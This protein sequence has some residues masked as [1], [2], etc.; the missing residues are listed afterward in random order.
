MSKGASPRHKKNEATP[1]AAAS[2]GA[3]TGKVM[4]AVIAAA[5]AHVAAAAARIAAKS[6]F[7]PGSAAVRKKVLLLPHAAFVAG[8]EAA[9]P[10]VYGGVSKPQP[11]QA[12]AA[13]ASI[14]E[15]FLLEQTE[16]AVMEKSAILT[17][18]FTT[19]RA[20]S[21]HDL[22]ARREVA[23]TRF[24][25]SVLHHSAMGIS[26][27]RA[28]ATSMDISDDIAREA[29]RK[30]YTVL[31]TL[32]ALIVDEADIDRV[33]LEASGMCTVL[34]NVAVPLASPLDITPVA[35]SSA[36][37]F[38][39]LQSVK[40]AAARAKGLDG[41]GV[42]VGVL[43]TGIDPTHPE[44]AGKTIHYCEFDGNGA[45]VNSTAHDAGQ[46][47]TH[48]CG[49]IA[50]KN[51]GIAPQASL[52]VAGVLNATPDGKFSGQ[53]V[54]IAAGMHWL[55]S[56]AFRSDPGVDVMNASLGVPGYNSYFY[57]TLAA[58][59]NSTGTGLVSA[60]GNNGLYGINNHTSPANY[61]IVMG[62]GA[63]DGADNVAPFSDWGTVPE[64]GGITKPNLS[65]PG[66][67]VVS[68]VPGG[69]YASMSGT[70]MASPMVAG[71]AALLAQKNPALS[72]NVPG[73]FA[74]LLGLLRP[75]ASPTNQV[76]GG[77]GALDLTNI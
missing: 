22:L 48:V 69:G 40:A 26:S 66:V 18:Q 51:A 44:F 1:A 17:E 32:G 61:D 33:S 56:T 27:V 60:I 8:M 21:T 43:D 4:E 55:L 12:T 58:A 68:S 2:A 25:E 39:H 73:L 11:Y 74:G 34:D 46:H 23:L 62:V 15:P 49:I 35:A 31:S 38:W 50:G 53:L 14:S 10:E 63:V 30:Q 28:L 6:K 71:A 36:L 16:G 70:S 65:A 77:A 9:S 24:A 45:P 52:A 76:R 67:S 64:C 41:S 29:P 5:T 3:K 59:R 19:A 47:G 72:F 42:L 57:A 75:F 7:A 37:N 54:Q 13:A 20:R